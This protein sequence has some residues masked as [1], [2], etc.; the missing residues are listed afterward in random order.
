MIISEKI[1]KQLESFNNQ[2]ENVINSNSLTDIQI[3][4]FLINFDKVRYNLL[5]EIKE[6][7]RNVDFEYEKIKTI[8]DNYTAELNDNILKLYIPEILPSFKNLKTHTYK[9][10]LLNVAEITKKFKGLFPNEVFIYIKV[11]DN[12]RGWDIDNKYVKPIADA[13]IISGVIEDDNISKMFYCCKGEFSETP[14]TLIYVLDDKNIAQF[15][16][17]VEF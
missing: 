1:N 11:C 17:K 14:H 5:S 16:K 12:I 7:N 10:I 8:D 15:L 6:Y 3:E 9:R 4:N 2:I 13:L